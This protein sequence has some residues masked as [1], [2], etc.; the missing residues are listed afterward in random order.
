MGRGSR[1]ERIELASLDA[2]AGAH[3]GS[4]LEV[5]LLWTPVA[6]PVSVPRQQLNLMEI[7]NANKIKRI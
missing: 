4:Q 3:G 6:V 1:K 5:S 2:S 7:S